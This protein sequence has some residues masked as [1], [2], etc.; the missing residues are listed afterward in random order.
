MKIVSIHQGK[1][2]PL[3]LR[4]FIAM[5]PGA[6]V[7]ISMNQF[8][9]P[10]SIVLAI[11]LSALVPAVWFATDILTIDLEEKKIFN[12]AWVMG[13]KFGRV[14]SVTS[15]EK[16]FI[17]RI[18]IKQTIYSLA[19]NKNI[20]TNYEY[21]TFLKLDSGEKFFM[22]SHPVRERIIEKA[23]QAIHKLELSEET[24]VLSD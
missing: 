13:F 5:I 15:I 22:F 10:Y 8:A 17:N 14:T 4:F 2:L 9:Q 21:H 16:V 24:L 12:G 20:S 23:K 6:L 19:N 3:P 1:T 11:A 7:V 18:E